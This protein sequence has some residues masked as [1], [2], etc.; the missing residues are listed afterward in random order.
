[1]LPGFSAPDSY[2]RFRAKARKFLREHEDHIAIHKLRTNEPLTA[3][4]L[5]ELERMLAGSGI[6]T[7]DDVEKAKQ[8]SQGL[9]LFVRSLVGMDREAAKRALASF[10]A[11]KTLRG[12]QIEFLNLV[13]DHLTEQGPMDAAQLY[14]SP[15]TNFSP[16]GV[17][18]VF[19]SDQVDELISALDE[20]RQRAIA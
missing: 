7:P 16:R 5:A 1:M 3:M 10:I 4:D 2:E 17:D 13:T 6:G 20:V 9:G 14:E 11:G 8:E 19:T 12:N 15:Y 18:G